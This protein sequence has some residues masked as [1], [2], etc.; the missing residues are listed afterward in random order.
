MKIVIVPIILTI[1]YVLLG[2]LM[3]AAGK[4]TPLKPTPLKELDKNKK[5]S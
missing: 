1:T 2:G 4:A 3:K 5:I